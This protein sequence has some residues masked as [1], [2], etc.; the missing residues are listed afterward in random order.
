MVGPFQC[1]KLS[2]SW[3]ASCSSLR[4]RL[5]ALSQKLRSNFRTEKASL[6]SRSRR[7]DAVRARYSL[8]A[9]IKLGDEDG[10]PGEL[11]EVRKLLENGREEREAKRRK[12]K[13]ETGHGATPVA[14]SS[15]TIGSDSRRRASGPSAKDVQV[16]DLRS[17]LRLSHKIRTDPFLSDSTAARPTVRS[18]K[19]AILTK[20]R[21]QGT[22]ADVHEQTALA[23][24]E[25]LGVAGYTSD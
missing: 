15:R 24:A 11:A 7:D 21:R 6:I 10:E 19:G 8:P 9:D 4:A 25:A 12:L 14:S 20:K 22:D 16:A 5:L 3:S 2:L 1:V 13:A 23:T 17:R 18:G